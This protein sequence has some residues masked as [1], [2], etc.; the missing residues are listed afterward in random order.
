MS[1]VSGR[2]QKVSL[3]LALFL[4]AFSLLVTGPFAAMG[5]LGVVNT[6][7]AWTWP[8][9]SGTLLES[10][11][12]DRWVTT[13]KGGSYTL[14]TLHLTY[15]YEVAGR[16]LQG[17]AW[18]VT[19][20]VLKSQRLHR[21]REAERRLR[22]GPFP[23]FYDP[24][25][26]ERAVVSR[27]MT[28]L[29][30]LLFTWGWGFFLFFVVG[31]GCSSVLAAGDET[32]VRRH[33]AGDS[34]G[35]LSAA[36]RRFGIRDDGATV[37]LARSRRRR[38]AVALAVGLTL[39]LTGLT[40]FAALVFPV[41]GGL[42][43]WALMLG[44]VG[45]VIVRSRRWIPPG[46]M[47]FDCARGQ[48]LHR[49]GGDEAVVAHMTDVAAVRLAMEYKREQEQRRLV[50]YG[51]APSDSGEAP[52]VLSADVSDLPPEVSAALAG[53]VAALLGVRLVDRPPA[54]G[55]VNGG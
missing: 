51:R 7:R 4:L 17:H 49:S 25:A 55:K 54:R 18:H 33:P 24:A 40:G 32:C 15:G 27:E 11:V 6:L 35:T 10:Q 38:I 13:T 30:F 5:T 42:W 19:D 16:R 43:Q 28:P 3:P 23:V 26:P 44:V 9:A 41:L 34:P 21:I 48:V 52:E 12:T 46:D 36:W 47:V 50:L 14:Y 2:N 45:Y 37:A 1:T 31:I 8:T 22:S 39:I 53:R 29:A 20:G